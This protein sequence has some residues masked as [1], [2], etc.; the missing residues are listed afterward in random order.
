MAATNLSHEPTGVGDQFTVSLKNPVPV[1]CTFVVFINDREVHPGDV[2]SGL[3]V[4]GLGATGTVTLEPTVPNPDATV[5]I[6]VVCPDKPHVDAQRDIGGGWRSP[7]SVPFDPDRG[8][9]RHPRFD[10]D[11]RR[12]RLRPPRPLTP[13]GAGAQARRVGRRD[14]DRLLRR[15]LRNELGSAAAIPAEYRNHG[16]AGL[17]TKEG[18]VS[19]PL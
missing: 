15:V 1:T 3:K 14:D 18:R 10:K 5:T 13:R 8:R 11:F 16:K 7:P 9:P 6:R 4:V 17:S 12:T 19:L 2:V